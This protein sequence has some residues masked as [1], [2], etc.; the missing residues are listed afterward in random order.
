MI[1]VNSNLILLKREFGLPYIQWLRLTL[2]LTGPQIN[3]AV[4]TKILPAQGWTL[5]TSD[6]AWC[7]DLKWC[8][9]VLILWDS[10]FQSSLFLRHLPLING[11]SCSRLLNPWPDIQWK[12]VS[13]C[14]TSF[15]LIDY[16]TVQEPI[17]VIRGIPGW[18]YMIGSE[19]RGEVIPSMEIWLFFF[20]LIEMMNRWG[21]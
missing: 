12:I 3:S 10:W 1:K 4:E 6:K 14:F 2:P 19:S 21:N 11:C 9:Q 18:D 5:L 13:F 7:R 17:H 15:P 8:H 16:V 20:F